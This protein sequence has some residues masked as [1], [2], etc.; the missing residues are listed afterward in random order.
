MVLRRS[1]H[2]LVTGHRCAEIPGFTEEERQSAEPIWVGWAYCEDYCS[3]RSF[4][5]MTGCP[6]PSLASM[7]IQAR[8]LIMKYHGHV[9]G[10]GVFWTET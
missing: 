9:I 2:E 3:L 7:S 10:N 4:R 5:C 6:E 8:L 1:V